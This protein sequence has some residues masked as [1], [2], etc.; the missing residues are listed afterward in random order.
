MLARSKNRD[1][2]IG[3]CDHGQIL[4]DAPICHLTQNFWA[5]GGKE[6]KKKISSEQ[7]RHLTRVSVSQLT[8]Q[9]NRNSWAA[10]GAWIGSQSPQF[11]KFNDDCRVL[12]HPRRS[13]PFLPCTH[14]ISLG[15]AHEGKWMQNLVKEM[16][17]V[18]HVSGRLRSDADA[19]RLLREVKGDG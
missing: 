14:C 15:C 6:K 10:D 12:Y 5:M 9:H 3:R 19:W 17:M 16:G 8:C 13:L 7:A 18:E 2:D 4:R 1:I 11:Q